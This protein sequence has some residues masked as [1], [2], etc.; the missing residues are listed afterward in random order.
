MNRNETGHAHK[1]H[2]EADERLDLR[3][4][5][6]PVSNFW[7]P[8]NMA[9]SSAAD[10]RRLELYIER[11]ST[12]LADT[13]Q[14]ANEDANGCPGHQIVGEQYIL[15][16][17]KLKFET[18]AQNLRH[19]LRHIL[20]DDYSSIYALQE[21]DECEAFLRDEEVADGDLQLITQ[22]ERCKAL[23]SN[24][25]ACKTFKS[26]LPS[27]NAKRFRSKGYMNLFSQAAQEYE[28]TKYILLRLTDEKDEFLIT[29]TVS[30]KA[31]A[32]PSLR[33]AGDG[34]WQRDQHTQVRK[35]QG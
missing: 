27:F 14:L 25:T 23:L 15:K 33:S 31:L 34:T 3:D 22:E 11:R 7:S 8:G 26:Q 32:T 9:D 4:V 20:E 10:A 16:Q 30:E 6:N 5:L 2:I 21:E 17:M 12:E 1:H 29:A 28:E 19:M 24:K 18:R 13:L 35:G